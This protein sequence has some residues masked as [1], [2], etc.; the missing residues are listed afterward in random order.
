MRLENTPWGDR[1]A[2]RRCAREFGL[3]EKELVVLVTL[4]IEEALYGNASIDVIELVRL[5]S[6]SPRNL[7]RHRRLFDDD[8]PLRHSG[9]VVLEE[10]YADK[11]LTAAAYLAPWVLDRIL[12]TSENEGRR[13]RDDDRIDFHGYLDGM[14]GSSE[15]FEKLE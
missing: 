8:A 10:T 5:V 15:F 9:A 14:T 4:I 6:S 3:D 2:L 1:F 12:A 11:P 13:I 7:L